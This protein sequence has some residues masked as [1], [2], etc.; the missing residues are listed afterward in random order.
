MSSNIHKI[1]LSQS[2]KKKINREKLKHMKLIQA[3][4][5]GWQSDGQFRETAVELR[6]SFESTCHMKPRSKDWIKKKA[7]IMLKEWH[8]QNDKSVNC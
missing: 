4:L 8:I 6:R 2:L 3:E 1:L 7:D 5:E